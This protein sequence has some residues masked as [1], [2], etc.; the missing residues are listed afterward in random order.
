MRGLKA[1]LWNRIEG[2]SGGDGMGWLRLVGSLKLYV[3]FAE[4]PYKRDDILQKET[5]NLKGPTNRS[6]PIAVT[7]QIE[8]RRPLLQICRMYRALLRSHWALLRNRMEGKSGG[9]GSSESTD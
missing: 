1:L 6:H 3:S 4:E 2:K 5:C 9:D 8:S 7:A